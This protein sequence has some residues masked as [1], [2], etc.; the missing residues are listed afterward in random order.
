MAVLSPL[1]YLINWFLTFYFVICTLYTTK[2][3][4]TSILYSKMFGGRF[5]R[6]QQNI[7]NAS[8]LQVKYLPIYLNIPYNNAHFT[9]TIDVN[10]NIIDMNSGTYNVNK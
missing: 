7:K 2:F 9:A 1:Q 3:E 5:F 6:H 4:N 10:V 8:I